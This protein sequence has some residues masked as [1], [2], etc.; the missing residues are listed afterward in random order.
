MSSWFI[1]VRDGSIAGVNEYKYGL[2]I[3]LEALQFGW[4]SSSQI[5]SK[6]ERLAVQ[7]SILVIIYFEKKNYE[8]SFGSDYLGNNSILKN[9]MDFICVNFNFIC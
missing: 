8:F 6:I 5:F 7:V 9:K 4:P 1:R 3:L 2:F